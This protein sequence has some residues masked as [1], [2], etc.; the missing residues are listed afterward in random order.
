MAKQYV[1]E[2]NLW[3]I[4]DG[5]SGAGVSLMGFAQG[6]PQSASSESL[7]NTQ[8]HVSLTTRDRFYRERLKQINNN[9]DSYETDGESVAG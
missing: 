7:C 3:L 4:Y 6:K 2:E 1:H 9:T 5:S 8:G